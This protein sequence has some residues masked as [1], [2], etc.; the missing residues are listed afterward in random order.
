MTSTPGTL[1]DRNRFS[2]LRRD[3]RCRAS[4]LSPA[5]RTPAGCSRWPLRWGARPARSP[6][7]R[8]L[9]LDS[10]MA[11]NGP[12]GACRCRRRAPRLALI[13]TAVRASLRNVPPGP[14]AEQLGANQRNGAR[15]RRVARRR[16]PCRQADDLM[17]SH[18]RPDIALRKRHNERNTHRRRDGHGRLRIFEGGLCFGFQG[19][20]SLSTWSRSFAQPSVAERRKLIH[21][22]Q[23]N[24]FETYSGADLAMLHA[25]HWTTADAMTSCSLRKVLRTDLERLRSTSGRG[26]TPGPESSRPRC[27]ARRDARISRT[28]PTMPR[29]AGRLVRGTPTDATPSASECR[30]FVT[31]E[32]RHRPR[33]GDRARRRGAAS[34]G[35]RAGGRGGEN[36]ARADAAPRALPSR[37]GRAASTVTLRDFTARSPPG[38]SSTTLA[39][40]GSAV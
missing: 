13:I 9:S 12:P 39:W 40:P 38:R 37:S 24:G 3:A 27:D 34:P 17:I 25:R 35:D 32:R 5:L 31:R 29:R 18:L 15:A 30:R 19:L 10:P 26:K 28:C 1:R 11:M 16:S 21:R 33:H 14:C 20:A 2:G 22:V 7:A 4:A 6:R 23:Q 8:V 36:R